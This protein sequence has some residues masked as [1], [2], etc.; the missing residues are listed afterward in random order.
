MALTVPH[1]HSIEKVEIYFETGCTPLLVHCTDLNFYVCKYNTGNSTANTLCR[2]FIAAAFLKLWALQVPDFSFITIKPH[3]KP[4]FPHNVNS[5]Q[6]CFGSR[7]NNEYKE[8][9][10]FLQEM[11]LSQKQKFMKEDYLT[12]AFF[13]LWVGNDDRYHRNF[14]LMLKAI[15]NE[16]YFVPIDHNAVFHNGNESRENYVLSYE[17]TLLSSPLMHSLFKIKDLTKNYDIASLLDKWYLYIQSC[18]LA[19]TDVLSQMPVEWQ[20]DNTEENNNL[21][22][23]LFKES[24]FT[25]CKNTFIEYLQRTVNSKIQ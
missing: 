9:D 5:D 10:A 22:Q 8:I 1:L 24:W 3:H 25:E 17:E 4:D 19:L 16:Y 13:D 23:F 2:E 12:I 18:K 21:V 20:V 11:S 15:D 7:F 14:N 6:P